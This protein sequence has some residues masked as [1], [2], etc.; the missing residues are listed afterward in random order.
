M[1]F[2][3]LA[4][5]A[6]LGVAIFVPT[7]LA[8]DD[9]LA[10]VNTDIAKL[11]ADF[12]STHDV[13]LAD[14]QKLQA[15]AAL[16]KPGNKDA[17]KAAIKAD[18]TQLKSD[19]EAKHVTM[20][21]DWKQLQTDLAAARSAKAGTKADRTA[22]RDA[23]HAMEATFRDGRAQVHEAIQAAHAAIQAARKAGASIPK[24]DADKVSDAGALPK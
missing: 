9:P 15:D 2:K 4:A 17:A 19:F 24:A 6:V 21:A 5:A 20:Q 18:W 8:A 12:T 11:Q 14:A 3:T 23:I 13:L 10:A 16:F 1:T 7:A 22:L